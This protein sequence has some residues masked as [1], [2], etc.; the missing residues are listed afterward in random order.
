MLSY[1]NAVCEVERNDPNWVSI[2]HTLLKGNL[3]TSRRGEARQ[4][5]LKG[6]GRL[7]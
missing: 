1:V 6:G 2:I 4:G 5:I 7:I 3:L